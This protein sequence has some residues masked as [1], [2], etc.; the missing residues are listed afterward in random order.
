M[1]QVVV[2]SAHLKKE[3]KRRS[4]DEILHLIEAL[5]MEAVRFYIQEVEEIQRLTYVGKGKIAEWKEYIQALEKVDAIVINDDLTPLQWR[6][7]HRIFLLPIYDRTGIIL[8][9][10]SQHAQSKEARLQVEIA[11][12][13]YAKTRMV[14]EDANFS[15]VTSGRGHNKGLGEKMIDLK[16]GRYRDLLSKKKAELASLV[17]QRKTMRGWREQNEI[18]MVAIVGYTNA[19]K[20][21]LMNA[22]LRHAHFH[23]Y[24]KEEDQ[25]FATLETSTR[26]VEIL[27][28]PTFLCTDTVGFIDHLPTTLI[29][30]FRS[31]LEEIKQADLLIHVLDAS[32]PDVMLQKKVTEDTLKEIGVENIPMIYFYN[33]SDLLTSYPFIPD[34]QSLFVSMKEEEDMEAMIKLIFQEIC[35]KW[36]EKTVFLSYDKNIFSL[37][38]EAYIL[39]KIE[40]EQGYE[41]HGY[42]PISVL[43]KW[44]F[45]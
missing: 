38:K 13:Q 40:K 26:R 22:F 36:V 33:K 27:P 9:I 19:G 4:D 32:D 39:Q 15:Q 23:K 29:Q 8:E 25:L 20:S 17:K 44:H 41:I 7:L 6:T 1:N 37:Q 12:I 2:I 28:Y 21:S 18:P 5:D 11:Q 3:D 16:R 24:V 34:A 42:F 14:E 45:D 10:F 35:K 31:T 43:K 30:A